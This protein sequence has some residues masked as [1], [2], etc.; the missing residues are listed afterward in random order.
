MYT[1]RLT[2]TWFSYLLGQIYL[3]EISL[4]LILPMTPSM[5]LFALFRGKIH[6]SKSERLRT[7]EAIF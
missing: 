4:E 7:V 2:G 3:L 6:K 1:V 5:L